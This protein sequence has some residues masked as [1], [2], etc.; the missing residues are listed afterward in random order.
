MRHVLCSWYLTEIV[1]GIDRRYSAS[2]EHSVAFYKPAYS[3]FSA[4]ET[5][6]FAFLFVSRRVPGQLDPS[7]VL[8]AGCMQSPRGWLAHFTPFLYSYAVRY[9]LLVFTDN[10]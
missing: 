8:L 7:A 4:I 6:S 2:Q 1:V 3:L 10:P 9:P 5:H